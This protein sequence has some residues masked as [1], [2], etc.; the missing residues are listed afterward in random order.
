MIAIV[1]LAVL[2]KR[3]SALLAASLSTSSIFRSLIARLVK[4]TA[5]SARSSPLQDDPLLIHGAQVLL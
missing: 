2:V 4:S 5:D 3:V 1:S